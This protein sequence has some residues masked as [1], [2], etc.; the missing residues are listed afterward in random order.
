[1]LTF[2]YF[3]D[4]YAQ[5]LNNQGKSYRAI[6]VYHENAVICKLKQLRQTR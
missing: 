6:I 1:M 3:L 2:S 5:M 4:T